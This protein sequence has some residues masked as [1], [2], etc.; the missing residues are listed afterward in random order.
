M[1]IDIPL[2]KKIVE[3]ES[4]FCCIN[5]DNRCI[6]MPD[7]YGDSWI[8][9]CCLWHKCIPRYRADGKNVIF[10]LVDEKETK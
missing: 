10:K 4:G 7:T 2:G 3:V 1:M 6:Y 8:N 5:S 9:E